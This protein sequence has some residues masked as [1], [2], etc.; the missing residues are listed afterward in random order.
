M[1]R[2]DI[3]CTKSKGHTVVVLS[4]GAKADPGSAPSAST[5]TPVLREGDTGDAVKEMQQLLIKAGCNLE[6]YGADGSFGGVTLK[7]VKAF[8]TAH[9]LDPDGICGP[10]TW[11][12]LKACEAL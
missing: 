1:L 6:K 9:A 7:A 12:A 8:Q 2:G 10:L 4:N 5:G 11:A 3:L